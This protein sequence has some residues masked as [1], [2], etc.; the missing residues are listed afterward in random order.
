MRIVG[1][2]EVCAHNAQLEFI[3]QRLQYM[4]VGKV[5]NNSEIYQRR[6]EENNIKYLIMDLYAFC[7]QIWDHF[8]L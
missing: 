2:V 3:V 7:F 1:I 4:M 5:H 8:Q 6:R